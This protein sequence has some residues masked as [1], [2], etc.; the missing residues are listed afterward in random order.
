[1][2]NVP[3]FDDDALMAICSACHSLR[4]LNLN[5]TAVKKAAGLALLGSSL[6]DLSLARTQ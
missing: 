6:L 2:A 4:L 3:A 1:M 5:G